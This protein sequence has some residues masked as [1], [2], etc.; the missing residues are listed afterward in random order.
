M[1][2]LKAALATALALPFCN[3]LDDALTHFLPNTKVYECVGSTYTGQL[4]FMLMV[5]AVTAGIFWIIDNLPN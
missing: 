2:P 4:C 5:L 3:L 1:R